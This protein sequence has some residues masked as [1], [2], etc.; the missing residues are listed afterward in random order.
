MERL[1]KKKTPHTKELSARTESILVAQ[2]FSFWIFSRKPS[3]FLKYS[4]VYCQRVLCCFLPTKLGYS[5]LSSP[6]KSCAHV[7][8]FQYLFNLLCHFFWT[9]WI[10]IECSIL[11]NFAKGLCTRINNRRS[12]SHRFN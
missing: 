5:S 11:S 2:P 10:C 6:N 12:G 7:C 8:I 1:P 3:L 4:L 9:F